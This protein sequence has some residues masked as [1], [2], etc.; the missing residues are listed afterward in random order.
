MLRIDYIM[1]DSKFKNII[2]KKQKKVFS[3]HYAISCEIDIL[4]NNKKQ[5]FFVDN[6]TASL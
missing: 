3:D 2:I 1:H 5:L 4:K 6:E